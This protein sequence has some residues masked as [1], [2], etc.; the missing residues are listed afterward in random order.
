M[1]K[2]QHFTDIMDSARQYPIWLKQLL[3][4]SQD[5]VYVLDGDLCI[6]AC[7]RGWDTF[8]LENGGIGF[9]SGDV[10]GRTIFDFIPDVLVAFY[11]D[12]Y[13]AA[14]RSPACVELDYDCSSPTEY[15]QFHMALQRIEDGGIVSIS[16]R[17]PGLTS[18]LLEQ[19]GKA[20]HPA[21]RSE[22][23]LITM[24]ANCRRTK[25]QDA[26]SKW[27][28]VPSFL[29]H[30]AGKVSQGI[31]PVCTNRFYPEFRSGES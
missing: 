4:T 30:P 19:D 11:V 18:H 13:E 10:V 9:S 29:N 5:V 1:T 8:A 20:D 24:C 21:Y 15:R 16:S 6:A 22:S 7:N 14:R 2:G 27:D 17:R 23:G 31:C 26:H 28:W 12:K 3:E 25:R